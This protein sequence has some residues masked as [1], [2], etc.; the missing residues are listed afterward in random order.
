M[1]T[2]RG[3]RS[4]LHLFIGFHF[5]RSSSRGVFGSDRSSL[6]PAAA[7]EKKNEHALKQHSGVC[8]IQGGS[9]QPRT[10]VLCAAR[11]W[12]FD[13]TV[14]FDLLVRQV[15]MAMTGWPGDEGQASHYVARG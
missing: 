14:G 7:R 10:V 3:G 5:T 1:L 15:G 6:W 8:R 2:G 11:R 13:V 9:A 4:G 12:W